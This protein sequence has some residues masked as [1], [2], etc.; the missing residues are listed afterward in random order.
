MAAAAAAAGGRGLLAAAVALELNRLSHLR[1]PEVGRLAAS[2]AA[3]G[4]ARALALSAAAA[5][6]RRLGPHG[7]RPREGAEAT[8]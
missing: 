2:A 1:F 6:G 4:Q 7:A 5:A 8:L 3:R